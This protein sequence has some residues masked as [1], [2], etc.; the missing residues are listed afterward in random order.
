MFLHQNIRYLRKQR[1]MS[2][3]ELAQQIGLNRGN[4]ASYEN[5]SAEPRICNLLKLCDLFGVSVMDLSNRDLSSESGQVTNGTELPALESVL[6]ER[7]QRQA[8]EM[9]KLFKSIHTCCRYSA[10]STDPLPKEC[11]TLLVYFEQLYDAA[12]SLLHQ[13]EGLLRQLDRDET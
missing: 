9:E 1:N 2:Q 7:Y 5:G 10:E 8:G 4:I 3:E 6:L 11:Q 12:S 13:H